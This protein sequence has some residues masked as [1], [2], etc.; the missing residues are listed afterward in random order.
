ML[1]GII[2]YH[3]AINYGAVL[4]S[5]AL[6]QYLIEIGHEVEIIDYRCPAVDAQYNIK[7]FRNC[8]SIYNYINHNVTCMLHAG[9]KRSFKKFI[10][11]LPLSEQYTR[12]D[13]L[14][15]I[16][17][18]IVVVGSDQV[19]NPDCNRSDTSYLLDFVK[20]IPHYSYAASMG[21]IEQFKTFKCETTRL[22]QSFNGISLRENDAAEYLTEILG[23][24]CKTVVDPVWLVSKENW[25]KF[26]RDYSKTIEPYIFVYNLMDFRFMR[27]YVF[28]LAKKT[29][30]KVIV[31]NRTLIGEYQYFHKAKNASNI[32][33]DTFLGL[34]KGSDFFVTDSFHGTLLAIIFEKQFAVALNPGTLTTNSRFSSIVNDMGLHE[35]V[36]KD[37]NDPFIKEIDFSSIKKK[38]TTQIEYSKQ[39]INYIINQEYV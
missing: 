25:E 10:K 6:S 29:G 34:I 8:S 13:L 18:D 26:S 37:D 14:K 24:D 23:R 4:Q 15:G 9:K 27:D 19:F 22:L 32:S 36:L 21:S 17:Y 5:Y 33:P 28:E 16:P 11:Q 30:L 3:N 38:M 2:T 7:S 20:N 39:Y 31:A 35:Q 12:N 1:I